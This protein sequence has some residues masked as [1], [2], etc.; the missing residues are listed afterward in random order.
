MTSSIWTPSRRVAQG[1]VVSGTYTTPG[2]E[3]STYPTRLGITVL[4]NQ[5]ANPSLSNFL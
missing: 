1:R 4:S 2:E 3:G 5:S